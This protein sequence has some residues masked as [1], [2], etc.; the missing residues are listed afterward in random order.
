MVGANHGGKRKKSFYV[1]AAKKARN[2][3]GHGRAL[4]ENMKG[5]LITCNNREREAV[6]EAYNLFNEYADRLIGKETPQTKSAEEDG[7]S[8]SDDD[9]DAALE[10]EKAALTEVDKKGARR[11]Q[12]VESGANNCIFIKT[13]IQNPTVI[14]ESLVED[15]HDSKQQKTRYILRLIPILGTCKAYEK[16]MVE[17]AETELKDYFLPGTSP[18]FSVLFKTRN[19]NQVKRE[20]TINTFAKVIMSLNKDAKVDFKSPDI[21]IVVEII[22][23]ICCVGL[24]R[25]YFSR[26]KYN[27]AE[28]CKPT[29]VDTKQ[30]VASENG[31]NKNEITS[32][33]AVQEQIKDEVKV[34][35][36]DCVTINGTTKPGKVER[37]D[38][39]KPVDDETSKKVQPNEKNVVNDIKT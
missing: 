4:V 31:D 37:D 28:M 30:E 1:N 36:E 10:K 3:A 2:A 8:N 5:F 35:D 18:T 33:G 16:N 38:D 23:N 9:I 17:L 34:K 39:N 12:M 27:L 7:A 25:N 20:D 15:V 14:V 32:N 11:F 22:R 13:T 21:C 24:A 19:N 6:R 26:K 29:E